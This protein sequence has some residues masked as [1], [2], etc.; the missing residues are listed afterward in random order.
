MMLPP[1]CQ[2]VVARYREIMKGDERD[3]T[4]LYCPGCQSRL[5]VT[6]TLVDDRCRSVVATRE[7]A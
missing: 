6:V 1:C 7:S 4:A 2:A 5:R 3:G